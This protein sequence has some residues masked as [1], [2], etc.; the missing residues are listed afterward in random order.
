M[1]RSA[2][3]DVNGGETTRF[4]AFFG[5]PQLRWQNDVANVHVT[6]VCT[7]PGSGAAVSTAASPDAK[8]EDRAQEATKE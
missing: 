5:S 6:Y 7:T 8:V 1:T 3:F 2:I 4:G